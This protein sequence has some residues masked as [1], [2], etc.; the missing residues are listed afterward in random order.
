MPAC[1]ADPLDGILVLDFN[2]EHISREGRSYNQVESFNQVVTTAGASPTLIH[3]QDYL[4]VQSLPETS[5]SKIRIYNW[6]AQLNLFGQSL[7][8]LGQDFG[9]NIA[10]FSSQ[11]PAGAVT[12]PVVNGRCTGIDLRQVAPIFSIPIER[13]REA[14]EE[15]FYGNVTLHLGERT[16][17]SGG[18]RRIILKQNSG[19]FANGNLLAAATDCRGYSSVAGCLPSTKTTIYS[20]SVSH[21]FNDDIMAYAS[22]G[23]SY[24]PGNVVVATA[25]TGIGPLLSQ[26]IGPPDEK[27]KSYE[28]GIK[29]SWLNN[30][31]TLN[32][33]GYYQEFTNFAFRPGSPVL[34]L[35]DVATSAPTASI[36]SFDG[37]VVPADAEIKGVEA[38]LSWVPSGNFSLSAV[39]SYTDGKIGNALFPCVDLN[40]DNVPDTAT[41]SAADLFNEVGANQIDT[42]TGS[43]SP[44]V[45]PKFAASVIFEYSNPFSDSMEGFVR[46]LV[47]FKGN[48]EGVGLNPLDSVDSL[49]IVDLFL[50][51]RDPDG[52]WNVTLYGKNILDTHR[53]LTRNDAPNSTATRF[54]GAFSGTNYVGIT[55]TRPREFGVSASFALG[56]H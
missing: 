20:A 35:R 49:A 14:K 41:P 21:E 28:V 12:N 1:R 37:L 6:Q 17:I 23:T 44:G 56:S 36:T 8:Y 34:D 47:N 30:T 19:L 48:N 18:A 5:D 53:V 27:S 46:G 38:E 3:S 52:A 50:G 33:A 25:F 7:N 51:V 55:T 54:S 32:L 10:N 13:F 43:T 22:Y 24:R 31:L 29:T 42:C 15:S 9:Q 11:D 40:D 26:F 39:A 4:G 2:Y 45:A 16:E